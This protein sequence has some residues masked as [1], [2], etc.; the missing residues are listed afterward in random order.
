MNEKKAGWWES[1]ILFATSLMRMNVQEQHVTLENTVSTHPQ[2]MMDSWVTSLKRE[3]GNI[4]ERFT[5]QEKENGKVAQ[6]NQPR[7]DTKHWAWF[8]I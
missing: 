8:K 6:R 4:V 5:K 3:R 7:V 2:H 1:L